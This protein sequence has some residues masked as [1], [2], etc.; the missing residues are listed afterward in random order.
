M[1]Y[2]KGLLFFYSLERQKIAKRCQGQKVLLNV[3]NLQTL[4][5][6]CMKNQH[7]I[8]TVTCAWEYFVK[9]LSLNTLHPEIQPET[10]IMKGGSIHHFC[11]ENT[12]ECSGP[13]ARA[14]C[15]MDWNR[16]GNILGSDESMFSFF[17]GLIHEMMISESWKVQKQAPIHFFYIAPKSQQKLSLGTLHSKVKKLQNSMENPTNPPWSVLVEVEV[18]KLLLIEENIIRPR[19]KIQG[20]LPPLVVLSGKWREKRKKQP[21][22]Q[23]NDDING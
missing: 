20:H 8:N 1:Q 5:Q 18:E 22:G 6:L 4:G 17:L 9:W 7:V 12:S 19:L 14:S 23:G 21:A 16:S 13:E 3:R 2:Y 11:A 10:L 15:Q